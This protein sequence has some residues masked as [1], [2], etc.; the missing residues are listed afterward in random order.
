MEETRTAERVK[1]ERN[2]LGRKLKVL[3]KDHQRYVDLGNMIK[4]SDREVEFLL[5]KYTNLKGINDETVHMI[6]IL[7]EKEEHPECA[8][9]ESTVRTTAIHSEAVSRNSR[10]SGAQTV[11]TPGKAPKVTTAQLAA[12]LE[13]QI[14]VTHKKAK[15]HEQKMWDHQ[16]ECK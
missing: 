12:N 4:D 15:R 5:R 10:R 1:I 9:G 6:A 13:L 2:D 3:E 11:G 14:E 8:H 16:A 7:S